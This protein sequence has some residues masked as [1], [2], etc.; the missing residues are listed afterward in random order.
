[1]GDQR[2]PFNL[3]GNLL[4]YIRKNRRIA[5][6]CLTKAMH[7]TAKPLVITRLRIDQG[8][9]PIYYLAVP[10]NH[11]PYSANAATAFVGCL[12]VNS[13]KIHLCFLHIPTL[14]L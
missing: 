7:L 11:Y 12:E 1:M 6:V 5:G 14:C 10:D 4:P 2:Q 8:I 3:R 13:R 9:E